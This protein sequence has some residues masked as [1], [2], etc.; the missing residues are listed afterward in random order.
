MGIRLVSRVVM[1]LIPFMI[2]V[3]AISAAPADAAAASVISPQQNGVS[4]LMSAY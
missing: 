2:S 3:P 4:E 1:I